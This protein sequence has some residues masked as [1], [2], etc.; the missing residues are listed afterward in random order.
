MVVCNGNQVYAYICLELVE[1]QRYLLAQSNRTC[2]LLSASTA[3]SRLLG[4]LFSA[5]RWLLFRNCNPGDHLVV[6]LYLDVLVNL[7]FQNLHKYLTLYILPAL[8]N[9]LR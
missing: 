1:E 2:T 7:P 6:L 3:L 5:D 9:L 4:F 8:S